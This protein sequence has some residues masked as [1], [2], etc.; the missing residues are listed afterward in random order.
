M[1]VLFSSLRPSCSAW[2]E[3]SMV[4]SSPVSRLN[5]SVF[6]WFTCTRKKI[7]FMHRSNGMFLALLPPAKRN[8][9]AIGGGPEP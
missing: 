6:A 4:V 1:G 3:S 8:S 2:P 7:G 5:Q 9:G